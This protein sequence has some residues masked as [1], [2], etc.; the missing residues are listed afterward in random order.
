LS[1]R[2]I[3][4]TTQIL[5]KN[6]LILY[7]VFHVIKVFNSRVIVFFSFQAH[8]DL[9]PENILQTNNPLLDY[10]EICHK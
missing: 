6:F 4:I 3:D 10:S 2:C 7:K 8:V 5:K 1:E 9:L